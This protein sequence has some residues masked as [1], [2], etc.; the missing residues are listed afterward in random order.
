MELNP[1]SDLVPLT[2][3]EQ[4]YPKITDVLSALS[5][6]I[7]QKIHA[8]LDA[9]DIKLDFTSDVFWNQDHIEALNKAEAKDQLEPQDILDYIFYVDECLKF[10]N[11]S[12]VITHCL[13]KKFSNLCNIPL[14]G[15]NWREIFT[16]SAITAKKICDRNFW[17]NSDFARKFEL[18]SLDD[19]NMMD[20]DYLRL[21]NYN[22][23]ITFQDYQES[24]EEL[25][26]MWQKYN[27]GV[28][29]LDIAKIESPIKRSKWLAQK[30]DCEAEVVK[31]P[32]MYWIDLDQL[33]TL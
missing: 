26:Q 25:S 5:L 28:W 22:Y 21:I 30:N 2:S 10:D 29:K 24:S 18:L 12:C 6:A 4:I 14:I 31:T 33:D 9:K 20:I 15:T 32:R 3:V 8:N 19:I 23:E 7:R 27:A 16:F 17:G 11:E 1:T 13:I